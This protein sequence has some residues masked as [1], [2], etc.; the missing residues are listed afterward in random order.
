MAISSPSACL[1]NTSVDTLK[2]QG[3]PF[4]EMRQ[5]FLVLK[6]NQENYTM[7]IVL[8]DLRQ[9]ACPAD[10]E[11]LED[12]VLQHPFYSYTSTLTNLTLIYECP[13]VDLMLSYAFTCDPKATDVYNYYANEIIW[14][15]QKP[16]LEK[17]CKAHLTNPVSQA[18]LMELYGGYKTV[19]E[20]LSEGFDV[21]Y[22]AHRELCVNCQESDGICGS[23]STTHD[24]LCL[25]RD[26]PR[27]NAPSPGTTP[28]IVFLQMYYSS[29]NF[30]S[31]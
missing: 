1:L 26:Q 19:D 21:E 6:I 9:D 30:S 18:D 28:G 24:F 14:K 15:I 2:E 4:G 13:K 8:W 3:T 16:I 7:K 10:T 17:Y 31:P 23:N 27:N 22:H 25:H 11:N 29:L 20:T 5:R 12:V